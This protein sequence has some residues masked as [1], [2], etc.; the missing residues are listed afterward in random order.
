M[1]I[2]AGPGQAAV[3]AW[4]VFM[5]AALVHVQLLTWTFTSE[6]FAADEIGA[7]IDEGGGTEGSCARVGMTAPDEALAKPRHPASWRPG[8]M[9]VRVF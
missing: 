3:T 4:D 1:M 2:R 9:Y 7:S 8:V 6:R 5:A